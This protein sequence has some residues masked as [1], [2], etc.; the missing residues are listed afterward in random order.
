[1]GG[2]SGYECAPPAHPMHPPP[3]SAPEQVVITIPHFYNEIINYYDI[4]T[5]VGANYANSHTLW[6]TPP[7]PTTHT[8]TKNK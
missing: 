4:S 8:S 3:R 1:M 5:P 2:S 6:Q 7:R